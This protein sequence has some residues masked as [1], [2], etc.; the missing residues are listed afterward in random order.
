[1][2]TY[3]NQHLED[4][5][6]M[7]TLPAN[8]N[9]LTDTVELYALSLNGLANKACLV[10]TECDNG[11]LNVTL[12]DDTSRMRSTMKKLYGTSALKHLQIPLPSDSVLQKVDIVD[13]V[14]KIKISH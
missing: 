12:H 2:V 4:V 13:N 5:Y 7:E 3:R 10:R 11:F 8:S 1:M 9:N 14:L 6:R